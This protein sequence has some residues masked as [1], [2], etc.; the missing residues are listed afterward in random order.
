MTKRVIKKGSYAYLCPSNEYSRA[1]ESTTE[2]MNAAHINVGITGVLSENKRR[3][4]RRNRNAYA[5]RQATSQETLTVK[6]LF[7]HFN[8]VHDPGEISLYLQIS[9]QFLRNIKYK[10]EGIIF[11]KKNVYCQ[12]LRTFC[13]KEL[14][15]F[16]VLV[17]LFLWSTSTSMSMGTSTGT[18]TTTVTTTATSRESGGPVECRL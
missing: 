2:R 3:K 7:I 18:S 4:S 10:L 9:F 13:P 12:N 11:R 6:W 14:E 8:V 5:R 16:L 15:G 17:H 1:Y